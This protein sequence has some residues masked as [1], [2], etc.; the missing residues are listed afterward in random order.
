MCYL[1]GSIIVINKDG[2]IRDAMRRSGVAVV[3]V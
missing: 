2:E 1:Y 3:R